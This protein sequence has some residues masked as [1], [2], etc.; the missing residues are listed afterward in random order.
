M[1]NPPELPILISESH[2]VIEQIFLLIKD[3]EAKKWDAG[4]VVMVNN[5]SVDIRGLGVADS[6]AAAVALLFMGIK[7]FPPMK[8]EAML[9]ELKRLMDR[10]LVVEAESKLW[11]PEH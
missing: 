5:G 10:S 6:E 11:R 1:T 3:I 8:Q 9:A 2:Q 7:A 4:V